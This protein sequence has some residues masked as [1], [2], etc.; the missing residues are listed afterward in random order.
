MLKSKRKTYVVEEPSDGKQLSLNQVCKIGS[1][2]NGTPLNRPNAC[3]PIGPK[4][5]TNA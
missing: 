1:I 4:I 5:K 3:F 2:V